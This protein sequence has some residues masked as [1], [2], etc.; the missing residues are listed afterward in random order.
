MHDQ[1]ISLTNRINAIQSLCNNLIS[2]LASHPNLLGH[3]PLTAIIEEFKTIIRI[4]KDFEEKFNSTLTPPLQ[5]AIDRIL[6]G[7]GDNS[8]LKNPIEDYLKE[9]TLPSIVHCLPRLSVFANTIIFELNNAQAIIERKVANAFHHLKYSLVVDKSIQG[10]W[11]EVWNGDNRQKEPLFEDLGRQHLLS[12]GIWAYK[13]DG[14]EQITDSVYQIQEEVSQTAYGVVLSEWKVAKEQSEVER[15]ITNAFTQ[16]EIYTSEVLRATRLANL[17]Y[18]VIVS[19]HRLA[20]QASDL[21]NS[22]GHCFKVFNVA[23]NP[24][25][26]SKDSKK[27]KLASSAS[28]KKS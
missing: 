23:I 12:H 8:F 11:Q 18:L 7:S 5:L 16:V 6:R 13:V 17:R 4:V 10:K 14:Y 27:L 2:P 3:G 22:Q 15:I 21:E 25:H 20:I 9:H 1:A 26:A 19:E 28:H 24:D